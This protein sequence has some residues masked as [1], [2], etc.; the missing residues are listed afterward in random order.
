MK[1][2]KPAISQKQELIDWITSIE[3]VSV[4]ENLTEIKKRT[5]F[6]LEEEFKKGLTI[7]ESK[8]NI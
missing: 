1:S 2:T 7:E 4:I 8:K 3:D 5:T 6:D